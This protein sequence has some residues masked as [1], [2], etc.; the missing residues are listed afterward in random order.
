MLTFCDGISNSY[1]FFGWW[2]SF[3]KSIYPHIKDKIPWYLQF[4]NKAIFETNTIGKF[5][6]L[7]WELGFKLIFNKLS[8]LKS[9]SLNHWKNVLALWETKQHKI[10]VLRPKLDQ[11][12]ILM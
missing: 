10:L 12:L 5:T 4:N 2:F 6:E 3:K 9:K 1:I 11:G 8:L 7:F